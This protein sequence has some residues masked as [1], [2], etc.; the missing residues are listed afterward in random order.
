[1]EKDEINRNM[2]IL[3]TGVLSP[4]KRWSSKWSLWPCHFVTS[5]CGVELAH[6]FACGFDG[7]RLGTLN[8]GIS[9]QAN[10]I[11]V[12]GTITRKMARALRIV[13]EQMPDPKFVVALGSCPF[14]GGMYWDSYNTIKH[15]DEYIPVDLYI[16]GCPPRPE[17]IF[18]AVGLVMEM[19]EGK[20]KGGRSGD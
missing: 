16:P 5:C 20:R 18:H 7:E 1:M 4:A 13:W 19:I 9:R 2:H 8:M 10:F 11:I 17:A 12:E 15:L 3:K 14:S 6:A